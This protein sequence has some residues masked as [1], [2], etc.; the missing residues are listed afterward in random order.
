MILQPSRKLKQSKATHLKLWLAAKALCRRHTQELMDLEARDTGLATSQSRSHLRLLLLLYAARLTTPGVSFQKFA[1]S[2]S[3][4]LQ[5][6]PRGQDCEPVLSKSA[7][8]RL[9]KVNGSF[10][11]GF[12]LPKST[13]AMAL[14]ACWPGMKLVTMASEPGFNVQVPN[15]VYE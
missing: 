11:E 3:K 6:T 7:K 5:S 2:L 1:E 12:T 15:P 9:G 8:R 13:S 4:A 10:P 14:P